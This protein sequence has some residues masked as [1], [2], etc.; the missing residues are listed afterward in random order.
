[1]ILKKR[2]FEWFFVILELS[3][4]RISLLVCMSA[5]T[6]YILA[7]G[8]LNYNLL[9]PTI[10]VFILAS[11]SSALNHYQERHFDRLMKRTSD[12][13]VPSGKVT[14]A[15]ALVVAIALI[16]IGSI[17]LYRSSNMVALVLGLITVFW[18]NAVYTPLKRITP[19][20]VIPGAFIGSLPPA[21]GWT[22]AGGHILNPMILMVALF[23]FVWQIPHFWL[24][25]LKFGDEYELAGY[26]TL[27]SRYSNQ[28][29]AKFTFIWI[30]IT[31]IISMFIPIF[32]DHRSL[33]IYTGLFLSGV[34]LLVSSRKLLHFDE[35]IS[36]LKNTFAD[37]NI[38]VFVVMTLLIIDCISGF[39]VLNL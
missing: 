5:A 36:V 4:F 6:G 35:E 30:V 7:S 19:L 3:K 22:A 2:I 13:P 28:Q 10:A 12:R 32:G 1:M 27:T 34:W 17:L 15:S 23:F 24:L 14:P 21:I 31:T 33:T 38:Y 37:I 16:I 29:I 25:L 39:C 11:G 9:L 26:P 8:Y 20:A 18:Y